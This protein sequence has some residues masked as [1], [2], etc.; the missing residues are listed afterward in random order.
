MPS[1][2]EMYFVGGELPQ[3]RIR[4]HEDWITNNVVSN[5]SQIIQGYCEKYNFKNFEPNYDKDFGFENAFKF[6]RKSNGFVEVSIELPKVKYFSDTKC[7]MCEG[8]GNDDVLFRK[9]MFCNG[10]GYVAEYDTHTIAAV[11]ASLAVLTTMLAFP[12]KETSSTRPQLITFQT[13]YKVGLH[14]GSLSGEYSGEV[15]D[16]LTKRHSGRQI[17]EMNQ[18]MKDAYCYMNSVQ[19]SE[20][21]ERFDA[22]VEY[23]NGWLNVSCPGNACGLNPS[24]DP[25]EPGKGYRF[26][27]HNV[28]SP[29]QQLTLISALAALEDAVRKDL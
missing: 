25:I 11:S 17:P 7:E 23:E 12:D 13:L 18:A 14:G 6:V 21:T 28:D 4:L 2:H 19:P 16:W 27:C 29:T 15:V 3:I 8:T 9:C 20:L 10:K 26:G 1:W 24:T 22:R 5:D